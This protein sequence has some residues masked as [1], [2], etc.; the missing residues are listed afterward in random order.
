MAD[1]Q[2]SP[3]PLTDSLRSDVLLLSSYLSGKQ[4]SPSEPHSANDTLSLF[5]HISTL[6]AIGN[7]KNLRAQNVNAVIGKTTQTDV[8][9]V[10]EFLV[11]AENA[12][13]NITE[14]TNARLHHKGTPQQGRKGKTVVSPT[15]SAAIVGDSTKSAESIGHTHPITPNR[16]NGKKL[17][18]KWAMQTPK[19]ESVE[20]S[21]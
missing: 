17:L 5:L 4:S 10:M 13:Q 14:V 7:E 15:E 18:N 2:Q 12:K 11:C 6:L 8:G 3:A 20:T 9:V 21:K 16:E 1:S 19:K